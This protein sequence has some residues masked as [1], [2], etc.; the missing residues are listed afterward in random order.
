LKVE[1]QCFVIHK[2]EIKKKV[3]KT[4]EEEEAY[5]DET[6]LNVAM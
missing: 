6:S 4:Y 5:G 3:V 2:T 1:L